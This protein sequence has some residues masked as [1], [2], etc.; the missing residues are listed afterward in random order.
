MAEYNADDE[1]NAYSDK[2]GQNP[3]IQGMSDEEYQKFIDKETVK[4]HF[5]FD[6]NAKKNIEK[7]ISSLKI[8]DQ[9]EVTSL[10]DEVMVNF[11]L[12]MLR[13]LGDLLAE[14]I[15]EYAVSGKDYDDELYIEILDSGILS[16]E[17]KKDIE[18]MQKALILK[19][20]KVT[21][22]LSADDIRVKSQQSLYDLLRSEQ[23]MILDG[24]MQ[25]GRIFR[26]YLD[27]ANLRMRVIDKYLLH[28]LI[29]LVYGGLTDE[30]M[31]SK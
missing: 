31:G 20:S 11:N 16:K 23:K 24:R 9:I 4:R 26:K 27:D 13:V 15:K 28:R 29:D 10:I 12:P 22:K 2:V 30:E 19:S 6:Y 3:R 25:M 1:Y 5:R 17:T 21:S 14:Y 18:L 7:S 8:K